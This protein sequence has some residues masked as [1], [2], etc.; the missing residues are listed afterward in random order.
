MNSEFEGKRDD[1]VA[2]ALIRAAEFGHASSAAYL[3]RECGADPG[4]IRRG[5]GDGGNA[6][7]AAAER[8]HSD[9][10]ETLLE[11]IRGPE[12]RA[13]SREDANGRTRRRRRRGGATPTPSA[14]S[15]K[16]IVPAQ[17]ET[18]FRLRRRT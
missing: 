1:A 10:L 14:F 7:H 12:R 8:G 3:L 9:V 17:T 15:F 16:R 4:T 5:G 2:A 6:L 13:P 18:Q 11:N